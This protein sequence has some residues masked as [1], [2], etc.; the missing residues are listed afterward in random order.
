MINRMGF[1]MQARRRTVARPEGKRPRRGIVGVN[2]GANKD[3][4]ERIAR[5]CRGHPDNDRR[6]RLPDRQHQLTNTPGLR[7]LR[8]KRAWRI[9]RRGCAELRGRRRTAGISEVA[10]DLAQG[11]RR[12]ARAA[13]DHQI[14]AIIVANTNRLAAAPQSRLAGKLEASGT[15]QATRVDAL[16]KFAAASG[17][18]IP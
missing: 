9:A 1:K 11:M 3:S 2:I 15:A 18:A 8:T 5:L 10:P 12:I 4:R 16:R 13:I 14:D 7:G 17:G 6:R